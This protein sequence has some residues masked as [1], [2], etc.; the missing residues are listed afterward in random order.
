MDAQGARQNSLFK[1]YLITKCHQNKKSRDIL[2]I[3]METQDIFLYIPHNKHSKKDINFKGMRCS[4]M[5][6]NRLSILLLALLVLTLLVSA[7][8]PAQRPLPE[9]N[10]PNTAP[11][12]NPADQRNNP[13][14]KRNDGARERTNDIQMRAEKLARVSDA[15]PGVED[16]TVVI[17]GNTCYVGLDVEGNL[18]G[19]ETKRVEKEVQEKILSSDSAITRCVVASDADTV[20][21]LENIAEGIRNGTPLSTFGNELEEIGR[22]IMPNMETERTR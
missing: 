15:V 11:Q 14:D 4:P 7:C 22:R 19:T 2:K 3:P 12:T 10:E 6:K 16:A 9:Q 20:S 5:K 21:R 17:S 18:Q 1:V 13:V 8:S